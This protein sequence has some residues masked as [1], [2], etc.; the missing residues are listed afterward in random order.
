MSGLEA[1]NRRTALQVAGAVVVGAVAM[2]PDAAEASNWPRLDKAL[3]QMKDAKK[4]LEDAKTGF[5]SHKKKAI[6]ALATA[7]TEIEAAIENGNKG[8]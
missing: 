2:T 5:G 8:G 3:E 4:F 1:L 6:N 7:I